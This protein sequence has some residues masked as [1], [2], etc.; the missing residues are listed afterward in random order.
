MPPPRLVA[1]ALALLAL[2]PLAPVARAAGT[3]RAAA[4]PDLD[5]HAFMPLAPPEAGRHRG[6]GERPLAEAL[7][8][9]RLQGTAA[10][11]ADG[12]GAAGA[13]LR[14][15]EDRQ[16]QAGRASFA[17]PAARQGR[18]WRAE[19]TFRISGEGQTLAG[20]GLALWYTR[21]PI[22][23]EADRGASMA[24]L[25]GPDGPFTG[26]ALFIDSKYTHQNPTRRPLVRR[27]T[28]AADPPTLTTSLTANLP[29]PHRSVEERRA[30]PAPAP[31]HF[32]HDE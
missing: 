26:M 27:P 25:G 13:A 32:T 16:G 10:A 12:A 23:F 2:A 17:R 5:A 30:R 28:Q 18:A 8:R 1:G 19:L 14:L 9:L 29:R 15:T 22:V 7:S 31:V 11:L 3:G 4:E 21:A 6:A 20:D 24:A